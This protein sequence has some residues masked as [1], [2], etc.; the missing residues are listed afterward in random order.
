[1][2]SAHE[3]LLVHW[4]RFLLGVL[5]WA[6]SIFSTTSALLTFILQSANATQAP[7][8]EA[9]GPKRGHSMVLL[10]PEPEEPPDWLKG[11]V[12][13]LMRAQQG[14]RNKVLNNITYFTARLVSA[15]SSDAR[16][17]EL[18]STMAEAA[19]AVGL[20]D[21]PD[22]MAK[23][24]E[25]IASAIKGG[26]DKGPYDSESEV[27]SFLHD[28]SGQDDDLLL[29]FIPPA[30]I[31]I[32]P[33]NVQDMIG[34]VSKT[35]CVPTEM[36]LG[37][38]LALCAA[39]IG[40]ARGIR[41]R[42]DWTEVANIYLLLI[43]KTGTGK[44]HAFNYIFHHL[45]DHEAQLKLSYRKARQKYQEEMLA[46]RKSKA[47]E[48]AVPKEPRDVQFLLEDSTIEAAADALQDNPR[49]LFWVQDEFAGFFS[50]LDRYNKSGGG[51]G[52]KR[53]LK[54]WESGTWNINRKSKDGVDNDKYITKATIGLFGT[55]QPKLMGRV[56]T[57]DD[58]NQGWPQ[59]FL[60]LRSIATKPMTLPTPEISQASDELLRRMTTR[61]LSLE[62]HLDEYGIHHTEFL[63]MDEEAKQ[64]FEHFSN[65]IA[66]E[67][68]GKALEDYT[69]KLARM[70]LRLALILHI[71]NW[72]ASDE[73]GRLDGV[74]G[75]KAVAHA[76]RLIEWFIPHT[77]LV[78]E[79]A[80]PGGEKIRKDRKAEEDPRTAALRAIAIT[81]PDLGY[82]SARE[83]LTGNFGLEAWSTG[84]SPEDAL[85]KFLSK[86]AAQE[87]IHKI[88]KLS[89]DRKSEIALYDLSP[90]RPKAK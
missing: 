23:I 72:A 12:T 5:S 89:E 15:D 28:S 75:Y 46:Y 42:R 68:W 82:K 84:K 58:M 8:A 49:G 30:P 21:E 79:E 62:M 10:S 70:T 54:T 31:G 77:E 32:F 41:Y 56:F 45:S 29:R 38:V 47:P 4:G 9:V 61:M 26:K 73:E 76:V 78:M 1:M 50:S 53:L 80:L 43:S 16:M 65:T 7:T 33:R 64:C 69:S 86:L 66:S 60:F 17:L 51:E 19:I 6:F 24:R 35:K 63:S 3:V 90:L 48:K 18:E 83:L 37:I 34:E 87:M 36:I 20:A 74:V 14:N 25:T 2:S 44:S 59:R 39:C 81:H 22:G 52:K 57:E 71:L 55:I 11:A 40:R 85:G 67:A 27:P 88:K 13:Q